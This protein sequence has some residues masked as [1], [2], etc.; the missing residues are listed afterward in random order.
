MDKVHHVLQSTDPKV[1]TSAGSSLVGWL[2]TISEQVG[3]L[4]DMVAGVVAIM[5]GIMAIA[6]TGLKIYDRWKERKHR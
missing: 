1:M 3:P 5:A 2:I 4:V 6:W